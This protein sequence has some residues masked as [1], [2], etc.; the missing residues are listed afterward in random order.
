MDC[1]F[2]NKPLVLDHLDIHPFAAAEKPTSVEVCLEINFVKYLFF[3]SLSRY[4]ESAHEHF[5]IP[6]KNAKDTHVRLAK[7]FDRN[8]KL[9]T[10]YVKKQYK[11]F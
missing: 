4:W 11:Q 5:Q 10:K 3:I 1:S 9:V 2:T 6:R 8:L 7:I